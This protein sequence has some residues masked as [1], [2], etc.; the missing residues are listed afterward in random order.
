M[1]TTLTG[2]LAEFATSDLQPTGLARQMARLSA[3]DWLACGIAGTEEPVSRL[4]RDQ[5]LSEAGAPQATLF[6]SSQ[7]PARMAALANGTISHALDYDDTHF[8]H[9]GHPSVAVFSAAF[10]V[11]ESQGKPLE[12]VIE[13]A[14]FGMELSIRVGLWLGR[15][16][17]QNG[18]HQTATAGA[19]GATAAAGRLLGLRADQMEMAL[20][21]CATRA[22]G[23]KA[24][25]GTMGKPYNAGL[26]ATAGVEVAQLIDAGFEANPGALEGALG[27]GG[28]HHGEGNLDAALQDLGQDWLFEEISHKFHAC[29]H[30][31]H[32]A[33]EAARSLDLAAPEIASLTVHTHP[34]W[35][36][37]CNQPAPDTGLGAKFSYR[38]VL[39]LQALGKDTARL[40]SYSAELCRDPRLVALRDQIHVQ[41]DDSLAETA[42]HVTLVRR[43]GKRLQASHDLQAPVAYEMREARLL[44]KASALLGAQRSAE[45][46]SVLQGAGSAADLSRFF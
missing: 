5:A 12:Q 18:Y 22:A 38:T 28:T 1:N 46:W 39:A 25:F 37:V 9:I 33:L 36:T 10:A 31:L 16:H 17:Y 41:A 20:G 29:C 8:A 42:A 40:D 34:R 43:D 4:L 23:L 26:A 7:V 13:A 32:A 2:Q 30:G 15:A 35:M 11:G 3:L 27:F 44:A 6:G 45:L 19:F 24:Q 14:L 21:L